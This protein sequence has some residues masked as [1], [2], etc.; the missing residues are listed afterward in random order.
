M[1]PALWLA[2]AIGAYA[3]VA[4][5]TFVVVYIIATIEG[6]RVPPTLALLALAWPFLW[7]QAAPAVYAEWR[8][9]RASKA[10]V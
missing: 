3:A 5:V 9:S 8:E 1:T 4:V 2:L 6:E 10:G 7:A